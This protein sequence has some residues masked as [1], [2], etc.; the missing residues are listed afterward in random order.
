M[1]PNRLHSQGYRPEPVKR[2]T[3]E[4]AA[5]AMLAVAVGFFICLAVVHWA[6][7]PGVG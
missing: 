5:D 7:C 3:L 4:R 2:S 1:S 6:A